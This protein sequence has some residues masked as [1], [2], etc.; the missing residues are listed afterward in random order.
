MVYFV[1]VYILGVVVCLWPCCE[2]RF[3]LGCAACLLWCYLAYLLV[4]LL[5]FKLRFGVVLML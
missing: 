4:W 2:C 1:L 5:A 3:G